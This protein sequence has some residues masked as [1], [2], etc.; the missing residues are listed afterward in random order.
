[1]VHAPDKIPLLGPP[2]HGRV[3]RGIPDQ[4]GRLT[5]R[6]L[7]IMAKPWKAPAVS[8]QMHVADATQ[9]PQVRLEPRAQ[10]LRPVLMHVTTGL[11]RLRLVDDRRRITCQGPIAAGRVGIESTPRVHRD[12]G[13]LLY[14]LHHHISGRL[15]DDSPVPADPRDARGPV[16]VVVTPSGLAFRA[17]T[18]WLASPRV[19]PARLG[20]SLMARGVGEVIGVDRPVPLPT[21]RIRP[22]GMTSPPAPAIAGADM[23]PSRPGHAARGTPPAPQ[24]DAEHPVRQRPLAVVP[25][26]AGEPSAGALAVFATGAVQ[27]RLV[28]VGAPGT[29]GVALTS[30]AWQRTVFPAQR[31]H[32]GLTRFGGEAWVYMRNTGQG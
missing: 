31:M 7:T 22:G 21:A 3:S 14:R 32:G 28:M 1:V 2:R 24:E 5:R 4:L 8:R 15:E 20:W 25:Q 23:D 27:A 10:A 11:L 13:G 18:P 30:G 12:S 17:S 9:H 16:V 26:R 19:L 29:A 6:Q